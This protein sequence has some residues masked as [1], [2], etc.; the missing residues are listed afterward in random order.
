VKEAPA[1]G[2][3]YSLILRVA[4]KIDLDVGRLGRATFSAGIYVYLG[5]AMGPG[6]LH[7]RLRHHLRGAAA[8]RWHIDWLRL[9][10]ETVG[11]W[12]TCAPQ[13]LECD[14]AQR[15]ERDLAAQIP[16]AG[17]GSSDCIRGCPAHLLFFGKMKAL[18][19][20]RNRVE[21]ILA[22]LSGPVFYCRADS[23]LGSIY[24]SVGAGE[25]RPG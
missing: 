21:E 3:S 25:Y 22:G 1:E 2:G 20:W 17:F 9:H 23:R 24:E 5:S 14:W 7:A 8:P 11:Y 16:K 15:L 4:K 13:P 12:W 6:G 18:S 10:A 19:D